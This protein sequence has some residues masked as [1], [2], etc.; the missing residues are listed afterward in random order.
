MTPG[1]IGPPPGG[2][3]IVKYK[4]GP[5]AGLAVY[6]TTTK[7][8]WTIDANLAASDNFG[9]TGRATIR[10][11]IN[12]RVYH[13]LLL[14][15][16]GT[17]LLAT[18]T[19]ANGWIAGMNV[20]PGF[21]GSM[22][23]QLPHLTDLQLLDADLGLGSGNKKLKSKGHVDPFVHLQPGF[24]WTCARDDDTDSRAPCDP[25]VIPVKN[26]MWSFNFDDGFQGTDLVSKLFYVMVYFPAAQ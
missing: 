10:S 20:Q 11:K 15:P 4:S 8:T 25:N 26:Q 6:D 18:A 1:S 3:G 24:Y 16:D 9:V 22:T 21:A 2:T 23:W 19:S 5:A 12:H 7:T 13:P 17:M 14:N